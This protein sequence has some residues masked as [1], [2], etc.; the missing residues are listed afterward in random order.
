V[1]TDGK[2]GDE[3]HCL[4]VAEALGLEPEIRRVAP[5]PPFTWAMPWGPVDPREHPG[6]SGSPVSPPFPDLVIASGRRAVPYLQ[7]VRRGSHG[8]TYT[9]F[10]KDPRTGAGSAD[11]IW[12]PSYD[13]IHGPN[14]IKTLTSPHQVNAEK[15][16]ALQARPDRRLGV[17]RAP[18]AAI[19]V[20]GDSR[21]H[22]FTTED[23]VRFA[24]QLRA[25]A[26]EGASLMV[27][28]SRRTPETLA[29]ELR[30]IA[31]E[32]GGFAWDGKG[33][34]PYMSMLALADVIVVTADSVNMISEAV[35]TGLP[36]LV[37]EPSGGGG[38]LERFL[39][40]LKL[41]GA[42]KSFGGKLERYDYVKLDST[43]VIA[44]AVA[45]GFAAHRAALRSG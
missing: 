14:V 28:A 19:L 4:A 5:R 17:L 27:T 12:A 8:S 44:Q 34:N 23:I 41:M 16:R 22:R 2:A 15:L 38:R 20:G 10:L 3:N 26:G 29:A 40:E 21:H 43:P 33:E 35:A 42:I 36:V 6:R 37:F 9:V 13:R 7:A 25:L 1:L 18:R 45:D 11:L 31:S 24:G 32:T 39:C 30:G